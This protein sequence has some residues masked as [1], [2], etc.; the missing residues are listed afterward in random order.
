M[1]SYGEENCLR[2]GKRSMSKK[3]DYI[4][5]QDCTH[6]TNIHVDLY[7]R[8]CAYGCNCEVFKK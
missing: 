1:G 8:C 2:F 6:T 3:P 4:T 7:G 5:C